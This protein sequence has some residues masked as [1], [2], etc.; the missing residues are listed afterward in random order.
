MEDGVGDADVGEAG[1]ANSARGSGKEVVA[2]RQGEA[3]AAIKVEC[4]D[5]G[6]CGEEAFMVPLDDGVGAQGIAREVGGMG[7]GRVRFAGELR[8]TT[9]RSSA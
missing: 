2:I 8:S 3:W 1:S 7:L 9:R 6:A 5:E 4:F